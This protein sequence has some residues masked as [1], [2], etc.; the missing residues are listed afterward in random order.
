MSKTYPKKNLLRNTFR[1]TYP[2]SVDSGA[3]VVN[4]F[5]MCKKNAVLGRFFVWRIGNY[6]RNV[7]NRFRKGVNFFRNQDNL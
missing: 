1:R 5:E 4:Y 3:K 2:S 6:F 7:V